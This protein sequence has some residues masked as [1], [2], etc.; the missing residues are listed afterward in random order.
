MKLNV[1]F[2]VMDLLTILAYPFVFV[3]YK[4]HQSLKLKDVHSE[5]LTGHIRQM[6]NRKL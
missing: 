6:N 1:I 2:V 3:Y 4:L 5:Q